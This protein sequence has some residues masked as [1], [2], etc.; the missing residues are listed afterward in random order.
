MPTGEF[1]QGIAIIPLR[2]NRRAAVGGEVRKEFRDLLVG[3]TR[4]GGVRLR[5][6]ARH[7]SWKQITVE[8]EARAGMHREKGLA[9][10]LTLKMRPKGKVLRFERR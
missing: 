3:K 4:F 1:L 9:R 2:V 5:F 7:L 6:H 10:V 8:R